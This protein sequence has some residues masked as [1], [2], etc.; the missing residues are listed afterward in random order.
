MEI[1][2][3]YIKDVQHLVPCPTIAIQVLTMAQN[4][5]CDLV[6]L[7]AKIEQ[8]PSLCANMLRVANSAYFGHTKAITSIKDIIVRLG[9]ETV[10]LLAITGASVGLLKSP[11]EAYNLSSGALWRHSWATAVMAGI[12]GR[13]AELEDNSAVYTSALLHD[14]GKVILNRS[15]QAELNNRPPPDPNITIAEFE[16]LV[17]GT[18]HARVGMALL[19]SWDLPDKITLPVGLHHD[20]TQAE[21]SLLYAR[22]VYLANYLTE[23]MGIHSIDPENY[24]FNVQEYVE[25]ETNLPNVPNF[26]VNM[27]KIIEEFFVQYSQS[28]SIFSTSG[29][30]TA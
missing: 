18:N 30:P 12:I 24:F 11:Q 13:Y 28:Q 22:I 10:K 23:S 29:D 25:R 1:E 26:D 6:G 4:I 5:E 14:I 16:R 8:D 3:T 15:L 17:L 7:A 2:K 9:V 20:R 27:E 19:Q 21:S